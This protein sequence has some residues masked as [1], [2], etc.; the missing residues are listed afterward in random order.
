M[1]NILLQI[2]AFAIT[3]A[4]IACSNSETSNPSDKKTTPNKTIVI[5]Y[6]NDAH[7]NAAGY[8]I[9]AGLR[10]AIDSSDTAYTVL[11]SSGDFIPGEAFGTLNKG[12]HIVKL[13]NSANYDVIA[14]GN[15]EFDYKVPHLLKLS[16]Q[17]D[18]KIVCANFTDMQGKP[19]FKPYII[20]QFGD[21]KIAFLGILTPY[22]ME[23]ESYAF[24]DE[25]DHQIYDLHP[26]NFIET[27]QAAVDSARK[28][29]ANYVIALSHVGEEEEIE[30]FITSQEFVSKTSGIDIVLDAHSHTQV[31]ENWI[32]N[33]NGDSVL[34]TQ[35]GLKF[36]NIGMLTISKNGKIKPTLIPTDNIS[37]RSTKV[38]ATYDSLQKNA[39]PILQKIIAVS[40]YDFTINFERSSRKIINQES[41][42]GNLTADAFRYATGAQIGLINSRSI[43]KG[44]KKGNITYRDILN[45]NPFDRFICLLQATGQQI[46]DALETSASD[47]IQNT[48]GILQVSGLRYTIDT[49]LVTQRVKNVGIEDNNRFTA[50]DPQA[51]YLV[52]TTRFFARNNKHNQILNQAPIIKEITTT[53]TEAIFEFLSKQLNGNIPETYHKKQGRINIQ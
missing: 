53:D 36:Q 49:S 29:G 1:K 18:A 20:K 5:L 7:S 2:T 48:D 28:E 26:N 51:K 46:I 40:N 3:V 50:I 33:T 17:I 9:I 11:I 42:M 13:L 27:I 44:L 21:K 34:V 12:E 43:R 24:F 15:H 4:F 41:G 14:P 35:T 30:G 31:A 23:T 16:K 52:A 45:I 37:V 22:T 47:T 10:D 6:D 39:A 32:L 19:I 8:P 25:Q 38:Q